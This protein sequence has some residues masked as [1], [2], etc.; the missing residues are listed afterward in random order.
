MDGQVASIKKLLAKAC[1]SFP[2]LSVSRNTVEE[3]VKKGEE[4]D[5]EASDESLSKRVC[6]GYGH[7]RCHYCLAIVRGYA[8]I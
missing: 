2:L 4:L 7:S 1:D 5:G 6:G 8:K 3:D